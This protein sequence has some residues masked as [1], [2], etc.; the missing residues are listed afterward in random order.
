[1]KYFRS[2]NLD[3][4]KNRWIFEIM[5]FHQGL[6]CC[7]FFLFLRCKGNAN[8][9][10][11]CKFQLHS[12]QFQ[13]VNLK[14]FLSGN[15]HPYS[16]VHWNID[17]LPYPHFFFLSKWQQRMNLFKCLWS[18]PMCVLWDRYKFHNPFFCRHGL[19][20]SFVFF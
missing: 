19:N 11:Y 7:C 3:F 1:M 17:G 16:I 18:V 9:T 15:H 6:C 14:I 12:M 2:E 10:I 4:L 5:E 8:S 20:Q 13:N